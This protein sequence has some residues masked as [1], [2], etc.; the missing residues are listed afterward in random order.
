MYIFFEVTFNPHTRIV[1]NIYARK[2]QLK[3]VQFRSKHARYVTTK[4]G[5]F[6]NIINGFEDLG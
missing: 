5:C 3:M 6:H 4:L 1:C 2:K